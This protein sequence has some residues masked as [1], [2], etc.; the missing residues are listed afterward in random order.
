MWY[1]RLISQ[2]K[3][4]LQSMPK[5][6]RIS[7][8]HLISRFIKQKVLVKGTGTDIFRL[9]HNFY[10]ILCQAI[11]RKLKEGNYIKGYNS[12]APLR[13]KN[14]LRMKLGLI[15]LI[16]NTSAWYKQN[17]QA[18]Y[19]FEYIQGYKKRQPIEKSPFPPA[20]CPEYLVPKRSIQHFFF[21]KLGSHKILNL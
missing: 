10:M 3:V 9:R 14:N 11:M 5:P 2:L 8:K 21:R 13:K 15:W 18:K 4:S 1:Q 12:Q 7:A 17:F 6:I 20:P 16:G 19:P